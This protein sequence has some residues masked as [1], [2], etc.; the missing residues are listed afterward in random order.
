MNIQAPEGS[1]GGRYANM[2]QVTHTADEFVL[3][4]IAAF[5]PAGELNARLIVSPRH[6]KRIIR[7]LE[8]NMRM[9]EQQFGMIEEAKEP[10]LL[11]PAR[12]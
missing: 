8:E 5:A 6:L 3:D 11:P 9:F 4:F 10:P 1:L 2:M 7:A 12:P